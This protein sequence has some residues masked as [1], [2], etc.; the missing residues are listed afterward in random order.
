[1]LSLPGWEHVEPAREDLRKVTSATLFARLESAFM[2]PVV[3]RK[4]ITA[5]ARESENSTLFRL[6]RRPGQ[7]LD[8]AGDG[9]CER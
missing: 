9:P 2:K 5:V 1:V 3:Y 8:A 7:G 6:L 4:A